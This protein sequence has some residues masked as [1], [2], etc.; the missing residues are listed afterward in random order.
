M[1]CLCDC[2]RY[3]APQ[4]SSDSLLLNNYTEVNSMATR[5][6]NTETTESG[7]KPMR[8]IDV[9]RWMSPSQRA[10]REAQMKA[11]Q[12]KAQAELAAYNED[13]AAAEKARDEAL[14]RFE[15]EPDA[16]F[17]FHLHHQVLFEAVKGDSGASGIGGA[18]ERIKYIM[19]AKPLNEL[20]ERFRLMRPVPNDKLPEKIDVTALQTEAKKAKDEAYVAYNSARQVRDRA[21][22]AVNDEFDEFTS[23]PVQHRDKFVGLIDKLVAAWGDN[24]VKTA[25]ATYLAAE[26]EYNRIS[27]LNSYTPNFNPTD[28]D[29]L[30]AELCEKDCPWDGRTILPPQ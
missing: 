18:R 11:E 21:N 7:L 25:E 15:A 8:P 4:H 23:S 28:I 17:A 29:N 14:A 16:Q 20:S 12:E 13:L 24:G 9:G 5:K 10:E 27:A 3:R 6:K 1:L 19:D 26:R 30:H 2:H 22:R